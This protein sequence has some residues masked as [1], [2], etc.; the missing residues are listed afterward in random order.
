[1]TLGTYSVYHNN[2]SIRHFNKSLGLRF[3]LVAISILYPVSVIFAGT[4]QHNISFIGL[5][6]ATHEFCFRV[7]LISKGLAQCGTAKMEYVAGPRPLAG[8]KILDVGSGGGILCEV[9]LS[10]LPYADQ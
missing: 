5:I 7:S 4:V 3:F 2:Y 10:Q 1:M 6:I 9:S 8:L